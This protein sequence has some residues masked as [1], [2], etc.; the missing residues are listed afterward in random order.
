MGHVSMHFNETVICMGSSNI[1]RSAYASN[2]ELNIGFVLPNDSELKHNFDLLIQ[3]VIKSSA[4]IDHLDETIFGDNEINM[5]G[6]AVISK[7]SLSS[8]QKRI[9]ELTNEEVKY[10]LNLWMSYSPTVA[11]EDLGIKSLPN[12]FVFVYPTKE[13]M[14]LESFSAGNAYFCIK[15]SDSFESEINRIANLSKTE[16]FQYSQMSKRGYH[17]ANKF[18]LESNIRRY[19]R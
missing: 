12:Y 9:N 4:L 3:R 14:V 16:I 10:R 11:A 19:F 7:L 5:E 1:S 17:V 2:Y 15:Y 6:S 8:V 18:T 13:L